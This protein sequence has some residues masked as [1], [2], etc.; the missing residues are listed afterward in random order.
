MSDLMEGSV[1]AN[2][3]KVLENV[4][5]ACQRAGRDPRE[6]GLIAVSKTKPLS[7]LQEAY[8][9]GA[10]LFGENKV[11]ELTEKMPA[12]ADDIAWHMI[13]HLQTNKIKYIIGK[14]A[15]I[16]SVDTLHL[17]EAIDKEAAKHGCVQDILIEINVAGEDSKFGTSDMESNAQLIRQVSELTNI[18]LM[19]LMTIAPYTEDAENN[20]KYFKSLR[21]FLYGPIREYFPENPVLSMGMTGD[22]MVAIEEGATLVR[23]GTGIFGER[24]YDVV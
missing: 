16:H 19:G 13:G 9:A 11:Q 6:V 5:I 7:M 21:E 1:G 8:V 24:N 4:S 18:R 10:R 23:V 3:H 15:L 20:R 22:Y 17:A 2:Y 14:V 12:M